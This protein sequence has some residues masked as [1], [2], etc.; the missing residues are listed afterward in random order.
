M[1]AGHDLP[2]TATGSRRRRGA[3]TLSASAGR[4][5]SL[6]HH[7]GLTTTYHLT[8]SSPEVAAVSRKASA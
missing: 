8:R 2:I 1:V 5:L 3:A 4:C 6:E 7:D